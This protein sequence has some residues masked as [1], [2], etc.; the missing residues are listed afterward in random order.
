[1]QVKKFYTVSNGQIVFS[2]WHFIRQTSD[3]VGPQL[4]TFASEGIAGKISKYPPDNIDLA[5]KE[6]KEFL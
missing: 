6:N 1:M 5:K 2:S 4:E 3:K